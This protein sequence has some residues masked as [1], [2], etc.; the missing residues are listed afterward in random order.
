MEARLPPQNL[1]AEISVLGGLMLD[2]ESWHDVAEILMVDHFYKPGHRDLFECIRDLAQKN[3]AI[4]LVTVSNHLLATGKLDQVGGAPYLAEILDQIPTTV[5]I[6]SHAL[7]VKEK[8]LLRTMISVN[9]EYVDK[10]YRQDYG[11]IEAFLNEYESSAFKIAESHITNKDAVSASELVKSSLEKLEALFAKKGE[12]TGV[13][14]GFNDLDKLT[15]GLQ[16]KEMI[17]LAARPS[18]GKT[19]FGLNMTAHAAIREKKSVACFSLEMSKDQVMIRMLASE[20]KV[21]LSALRTG[22]LNEK[23]WPRLINAAAKI[24]EANI[25]ID[26]SS[27]LSPFELHAKARRIKAKKGLDLIIVDYLQLMSLKQR[28]ESREREVS[29]ISKTLKT[30]AKDLDVPVLA[31]A[32][33]NRSVESRN[34]RR[35]LLSDLRE[36]GSIEQD[37]DVIMMLYREDYYERDTPEVKGLAEVI[38]GKQR[39]GPVGQ[40]KV[41]WK[42]EYGLFSNNVDGDLGQKAPLDSIPKPNSSRPKNFAPSF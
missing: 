22:Q 18:M 16:P 42:A 23:D 34:N 12:L 41:Q 36:S 17:I 11:D 4:D 6:K 15:A 30:I 26:D 5:N 3:Q 39:N 40:V 33:L 8:A 19:A 35:P 13:S 14:T 29:E 20:A 38:I 27:G 1:S 28:I 7:I 25:F 24:S 37:A 31:L 2:P 21:P 9:Q 32:Q 10:A